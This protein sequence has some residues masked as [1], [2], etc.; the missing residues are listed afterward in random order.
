[1][2]RLG[3]GDYVP[4]PEVSVLYRLYELIRVGV[5]QESHTLD[6][7]KMP[8]LAPLHNQLPLAWKHRLVDAIV[9]EQSG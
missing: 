5:C 2:M 4:T 9:G 7:T 3:E 8:G 1:M 6:S